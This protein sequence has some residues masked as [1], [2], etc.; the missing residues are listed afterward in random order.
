MSK[1]LLDQIRRKIDK[2]TVISFDIFDTLLVRPYVGPRDLFVHM[3]KAYNRP[4]YAAERYSAERRL[5]LRHEEVEDIPFARIYEEINAEYRDLKQHE[6]EW[7]EMVLRSNPEVKQVYDYALSKGKRIIIATDMYLP[8]EFIAHILNKNGYEGWEKLYVSG[9][10]GKWKRGSLFCH[11]IDELGV[12]GNEILHIGDNIECDYNVPKK[13]GINTILTKK[14]VNAYI[15]E[16]EKAR[17]Y[18][19]QDR[20]DF[21]ASVLI[22]IFAYIWHMKRCEQNVKYDYWHELGLHYTGPLAYGF[23]RFVAQKAHE[24]QIDHLLFIS[25]SGYVLKNVFDTFQCNF[26]TS[27]IY[28]SR[29]IRRI[30]DDKVKD[31]RT[32]YDKLVEFYCSEDAKLKEKFDNFTCKNKEDLLHFIEIN[33]NAIHKITQKKREAYHN[34][35]SKEITD[36]KKCA[37]VDDMARMFSAQLCIEEFLKKKIKGYYINVLDTNYRH[38]FSYAG[39]HEQQGLKQV[40]FDDINSRS[41]CWEFVEFLLGAPQAPICNISENGIHLREKLDK[42]EMVRIQI[43]DKQCTGAC[44]FANVV[45]EF[46]GV[47]D[48]MIKHQS[49]VRWI[50]VYLRNPSNLD[51][52]MFSKIRFSVFSFGIDKHALLVKKRSFYEWFVLKHQQMGIHSH[53]KWDKGRGLIWDKEVSANKKVIRLFGLPIYKKKKNADETCSKILWGLFKKVSDRTKKRYYILNVR[54]FRKNRNNANASINYE[55]ISYIVQRAITIASLHG[56]TFA[57]YKSK[58]IGQSVSLIAAGPT[59]KYYSPQNESDI[60][61]GVNRSILLKDIH[62][63][64]L[65]AIDKAGLD[66]GSIDYFDDFF[67]YECVKFVGDQNLGKDFQISESVISKYRNVFRYKTTAAYKASRPSLDIECA[68]LGNYSSVALQAMQFIL[69]TNP[70]RVYLVGMDCT[71]AQKAH[72]AGPSI[73]YETRNENPV[74]NDRVNLEGWKQI[75]NFVD[76]YYPETE[77]I[78]INPVGLRGIFKDVYTRSFLLNNPE[79][80]AKQVTIFDKE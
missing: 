45:R 54:V 8:T 64:Y 67:N 48:A 39:F 71:L 61:V 2:A 59:V 37:V 7:E 51:Y 74:R 75:K 65:F 21:S 12:R 20:H 35:L 77:I 24:D 47:H 68:P 72:F 46:F 42:D 23:G 50:N 29:L 3:E 9:D 22:G 4:G 30:C 19:E 41:L 32:E 79:I 1:L 58:H 31:F 55:K 13:F 38:Q 56:K 15:E 73:N 49:I 44:E 18:L 63:D 33:K 27:Y 6:L 69:Y 80:D 70:R 34:Y 40:K 43:A 17:I 14:I 57:G 53:F 66:L 78:S 52:K 62:F 28:C 36:E 60:Y 5:R 76:I 11:I 25:R 26:Q 16:N 10:I